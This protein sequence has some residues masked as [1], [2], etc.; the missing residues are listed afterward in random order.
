MPWW[1]SPYQGFWWPGNPH[2]ATH[3]YNNKMFVFFNILQ[4][5]NSIS[6][7]N[8][9]KVNFCILMKI[10]MKIVP[11]LPVKISQHC[12]RLH[13]YVTN[14]C[15]ALL[16]SHGILYPKYSSM[17]IYSTP[18]EMRY[19]LSFVFRWNGQNSSHFVFNIAIYMTMIN[20]ESIAYLSSVLEFLG[21]PGK[22][23]IFFLEIHI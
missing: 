9:S 20:W 19:G 11:R 8:F 13:N 5:V 15:S 22:I 2:F 1:E 3:P 7:H 16:I 21:D 14:Q 10:A 6:Y 12:L 18:M 23:W 17:T 4:F